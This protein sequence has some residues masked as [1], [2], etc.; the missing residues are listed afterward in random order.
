MND[1]AA[2]EVLHARMRPPCVSYDREAFE[3]ALQAIDDRAALVK[4][5]DDQ[6]S[7]ANFYATLEAARRH[8][9]GEE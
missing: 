9:R 7:V 8:V 1:N 5:A 3:Y 4:E 6:L 2:K